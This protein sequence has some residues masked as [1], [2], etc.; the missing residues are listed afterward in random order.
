MPF[1]PP[2][3]DAGVPEY[4]GRVVFSDLHVSGSNPG[5]GNSEDYTAALGSTVP[6]GC[7]SSATLAA[8][9]DALEFILF[10]LSSCVTPVGYP[11]KPPPAPEAG[12]AQ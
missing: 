2:I 10:D 3:S 8:D 12:T 7:D 11:P 9:E 6:T 4:C 5:Q 1:N